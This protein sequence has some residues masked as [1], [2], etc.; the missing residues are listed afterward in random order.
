MYFQQIY[1]QELDIL[2]AWEILGTVT[3]LERKVF[4]YVDSFH[5]RDRLYF[6]SQ[7]DCLF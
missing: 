2:V 5:R 3:T 6:Y 1:N 7:E 4:L